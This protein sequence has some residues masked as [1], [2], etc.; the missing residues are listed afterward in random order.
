MNINYI[1]NQYI[2]TNDPDLWNCGTE[3]VHSTTLLRPLFYVFSL[4][5]LVGSRVRVGCWCKICTVT[6]PYVECPTR[7]RK[8]GSRTQGHIFVCH[9]SN[10]LE[11]ALAMRGMLILMGF[12]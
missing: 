9:W 6:T 11:E 7:S 5:S 1:Q 12:P 4:S 2:V 8:R 3:W 10:P